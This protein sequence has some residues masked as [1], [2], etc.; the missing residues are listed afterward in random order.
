MTYGEPPES[1]STIR[2][3]DMLARVSAQVEPDLVG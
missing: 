1:K 2:L 3:I